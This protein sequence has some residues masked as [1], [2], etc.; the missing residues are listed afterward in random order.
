[1]TN[2]DWA[3]KYASIGW[4]V[5]PVIAK[6]KT[7]AC[8]NGFLDATTDIKQITEWWTKNP[9]YNI[10]IRCG[11]DGSKILCLDIDRKKDKDGFMWLKAQDMIPT[12]EQNT[13]SG[14]KQF[15]F[16]MPEEHIKSSS[17]EIAT[18]VDIRGD[19]GYFVAPPSVIAKRDGYDYSGEYQWITDQSPFEMALPNTPE[20]LLDVVRKTTIDTFDVV[21][22]EQ[23]AH[24]S[25]LPISKVIEK[26]NIKLKQ[27]TPGNYAGAHPTHGS[28]NGMNFRVD[29]INNQWACWRHR[30]PGGNPVGGGPLHLIAMMEGI[31]EC[32]ECVPHSLT[33]DRFKKVLSIVESK[34]G[35]SQDKFSSESVDSVSSAVASASL[36]E[37]RRAMIAEL[38]RIAETMAKMK[39]SDILPIFSE[40]KK[41]CKLDGNELKSMKLIVGERRRNNNKDEETIFADFDQFGNP[42]D[43]DR[44][45][46]LL[47]DKDPSFSGGFKKELFSNEI[48]VFHGDSWC[49]GDK[50][51]P[52]T[53]KDDDIDNIKRYIIDKYGI[54]YRWN[55]VNEMIRSCAVRNSY[56]A[57]RDY[58]TSLKWD[59]VARL[60]GWL[61]KAFK[62]SD[63]AYHRRIG[64]MVLVAATKRAMFPAI[65]YDHVL[66]LA[67]DQSIMKSTAIEALAGEDWS[68][69]MKLDDKDKEVVHKMQGKWIIELSEGIPLKKKESD[70]LKMFI[71]QKKHRERFAYAR[72]METYSRRSIFI[73]TINPTTV[74][75]LPDKTGNR[76]YLIVRIK[77]DID[78]QWIKENRDQLFAEAMADCNKNYEIFLDKTKD[79]DVL[80]EL[81]KEHTIAEI[82]DDWE[83]M[84]VSWLITGQVMVR[85]KKYNNIEISF[86]NLPVPE[87]SNC[88]NIFVNVFNGDPINYDPSKHG[89]RIGGILTKLGLKSRSYRS[90]DDVSRGFPIRELATALKSKDN[91]ETVKMAENV[92]KL[93][94]VPDKTEEQQNIA[95]EE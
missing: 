43:S 84:I 69:E 41:L 90:G 59:G 44:N 56:D 49:S 28:T 79:K 92:K 20:W 29:M 62:V 7:P 14:G 27:M 54:Q 6:W 25:V 2:L 87:Y 9:N 37:D 83:D 77:N 48:R 53:I 64:K 10:G 4:H 13:P 95:W 55:S 22:P 71:V 89:R 31:L 5:F 38:K 80:D 18:G 15:I 75:Y 26:Y 85:E 32:G 24:S 47:L 40:M 94:K 66:V 86:V 3:L 46:A 1:M 50:H 16:L 33:G 21:D 39:D 35:L 17:D 63:T 23:K 61:P 36:I 78:I 52:R 30:K 45:I 91:S 12:I 76:R 93:E 42:K 60:E 65:K 68:L 11:S 51:F 88:L 82:K 72:N 57:L 81:E 67:G 74:G 73:M 70:E 8:K 34:F 58:L 19:G